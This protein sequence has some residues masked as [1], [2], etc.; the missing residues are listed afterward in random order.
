MAA[1][2]IGVLKGADRSRRINLPSP[3]GLPRR[4]AMISITWLWS[5]RVSPTEHGKLIAW[6]CSASEFGQEGLPERVM[7][8]RAMNRLPER[9]GLDFPG[10][11][12]AEKLPRVDA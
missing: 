3:T 7:S 1:G 5:E 12:F 2:A 9:T 10:G 8:R 6:L 4:L 11:Q